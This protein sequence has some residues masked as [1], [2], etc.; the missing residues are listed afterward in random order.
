M[1]HV[2]DEPGFVTRLDPKGMYSLTEAFPDQC[3]KALEIARGVAMPD[4]EARPNV[5]TLSGLGGS[6]AGGDLVRAIFEAN[7][8]AP[9]LVNRDYTLPNFVGLGDLVFCA[10]YSGNTEETL[11]AYQSA[12]KSAA[13]II[14]VT[15]GGKLAEMAHADGNTVIEIPGGQPPRT[16]LGYMFI[17]VLSACERLNLVPQQDYESAFSVLEECVKRWSVSVPLK[18]NQPKQLA[19]AMHGR[20]GVLYGLGS[21]QATVANRWKGQINENAKNMASANAFPELNHNEILGWVK[22]TEQGVSQWIALFLEDGTESEKMKARAR[23][24][25]QLISKAAKVFRVKAEGQSLL[26]RMLSLTFFGD[27]LSL[28]LAALNGVDPENI[29]SIN[30]LKSELAKID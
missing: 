28:Y 26:Q 24:T 17:P 16:A 27:F 14:C 18:E 10:S 7:G 23:V 1:P 29:D 30:V 25:E 13:R 6:A 22:A 4:L 21:Y 20:V 3:R 11:S 15:S 12:K 19:D 5:V 8:S 2:L 9:F